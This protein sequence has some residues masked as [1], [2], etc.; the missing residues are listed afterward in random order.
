MRRVRILKAAAA[1]L[2]AAATWYNQQR[3]GL[4]SEFDQAI[5]AALDLLEDAI[6][7]LTSMPGESG[8]R[9]AMRL[10]LRRFPYDIVVRLTSAEILV[11]AIAHQSRR[12]G[13]WRPRAG[14]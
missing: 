13:Y 5:D 12:P 8:T 11:V 7:P 10:T 4:G 2:D 14:P 9:G 1:E 6:V 3:P